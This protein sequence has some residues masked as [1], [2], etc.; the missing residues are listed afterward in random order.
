M[1]RL[2][3]HNNFNLIRL[4]AAFQVMLVHALNHFEVKA[5][6][7]EL[8]KA[9]PGVP[10]FF[11]I[12]G[13]LI[14]ASYQRMSQRGLGAFFTNRVLRIYPGL[15]AC[16]LLATAAVAA[17]GYLAARDVAPGR[18][19]LWMLGQGTFVQF[20]NPDFMR[21]FGVGVLNGA[22]WT[23][24]VE[25][26]FYLLV[27]LLAVLLTR[28]R[29]WFVALLALSVLL[30]LWAH[31]VAPLEA[32]GTKLLRVSFLPWVYM[33]MAGFVLAWRGEWL[34]RVLRVGWLPLLAGYAA[35]MVL[36]GG[37]TA[38]AQNSINP[39]AF[40]FLACLV[41]KLAH[42]RLPLPTRFQRFVNDA[43]L[44]YGLYL[45]HMPII[46]LLVHL[47]L[48]AVLPSIAIVV[49]ASLGA[50]ALSWYA[51]ERPALNHKR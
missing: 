28:H 19:L 27:P 25:L 35:S 7:V 43:D 50:A 22:L 29:L 3:H 24:T 6:W 16:V 45:Y 14:G 18:V 47:G 2:V 49:A 4:A 9:T 44:S 11:V 31:H 15:V 46:N 36:I 41:L 38:N 8:L 30:N 34:V 21:A 5:L 12:S 20:Y 17:T 23:I 51:I 1:S 32:L 26:Q 10:M 33:F 40:A 42:S 39:V 13:Y 48:F 37:Y